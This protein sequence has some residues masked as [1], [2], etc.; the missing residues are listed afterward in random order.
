MRYVGA[1]WVPTAARSRSG[2][3]GA[4][5]L[6]LR[7]C[8]SAKLE[9]TE[10]QRKKVTHGALMMIGWGLLLPLGAVIAKFGKG[11][12]GNVRGKPVWFWLHITMQARAVIPS[13]PLLF[14]SDLIS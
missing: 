11:K 7:T 3:H 1:A 10:L 14:S 12:G 2:G 4:F 5:S 13:S 8:A 9:I 6:N